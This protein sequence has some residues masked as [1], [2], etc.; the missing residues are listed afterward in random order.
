ML[1]LYDSRIL[2]ALLFSGYLVL[3]EYY[4]LALRHF[5]RRFM[6][7]EFP[8]SRFEVR[9]LVEIRISSRAVSAHR[10]EFAAIVIRS[11]VGR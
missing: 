9:R 4:Y 3:F 2:L 8:E 11:R 6:L 10:P 5:A 1:W 7:R